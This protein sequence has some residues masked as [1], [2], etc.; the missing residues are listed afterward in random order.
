VLNILTGRAKT[1]KSQLILD[2]IAAAD[3]GRG[4]ILLVPEHAS[5]QA[6]VDLCRACGDSASRRAEV[7][8][9][10]RLCDRVLSITG[11]AAQVTLDAGGKLLTLEKALLEVAPELTVY[12]RPSRKSAFLRQLLDLFDELRCYDVS[13]ET[14]YDQ[15]QSITGATRDKLRDLSLLYGAYESRLRRPGLDARDRMTKLCDHLESSGYAL[16]KDIYIDGFTYFTAQERRALSILLRQSRSLTVTLLGEPDSREEIFEASLRTLERLRRLAAQEGVPVNIEVLKRADVSPLGHLERCFFGGGAPY[17]GDAPQIR[18]LQADNPFSEVEQTA[19]AIRRLLAEGKC[20]CRDVTVAARNMETYES[21]IE[22]VFERYDLPAYLSRRS[23]ILEKPVLSLLTGVLAAIGGGYEYDDMFRWLKTGLSGL[24]P[25]ECD[26]LENYVLKWEVH[27]GMWLRDVDWAENPDGYGAPWTAAR[28]ARLR[29]VNALRRRVRAPLF[30]LA[31]GLK[32][33]ETAAAKVDALYGFMEELSLQDALERQLRSQAE[34]GRLQEAEETAQL[35]EILCG[36]LDQFVEILGEEPMELEEFTRLFRQVLTQYSVG[37]I[38]VALDQVQ[39]S[40]VARNDRHTAQ[41]LFLL[42]ANDHVLPTPGEGGGI[43][44]ADDRDELA[45]RGIELAPTGMDQLAIELQN[46]YA[47]L[48][49]PTE[50]LTVS[51]PM[52]DVSGAELRPAFVVDRL[53]ALF[54]TLRVL[55][56]PASRPY[57]LAAP[58]PALE[59]AVPG[60][61]LW[62][63]FSREPKFHARLSAQAAAAAMTRGSLSPK[64]VRALYGDRVS[65]TASRLERIRSCH[66]AYFMEYGL[67]AQPRTPAA[68]DAPQIGTFLHYLLERVTRDVLS[69]GGFAQVGEETLHALVRTYIDEYVQRELRNFQNRNARF[70]Y[71]F[72][73]LRNLAYAVVDQAA[74][75]LRH[76]DFVPL[77]F[78]LSF[79]DGPGKDLPSVVISEPDGE[80]RVGGKVDRVDGWLKD[81]KL[82]LRV[83]DYKSGKKSFD[84]S[85]VRMGLDIQM[86]LY[87]FTLQKT[88]AAHFGEAIEPAGVL[89]LPARDDILSV[90]RNIPPEKL[91]SERE[92][93]LRRSGLLLA[94]PQVLQAMEHEA[95]TEPRYLP[96]RVNKSGNLSG[97]LASAVQLGKLAQYVERLLH[98]I[99][100]EIRQGNIDADPCCHTEED[101]HCRY[102]DWASACHFQDGRDG[103]HL[104]YILPVKPE[105]FWQSLETE[106]EEPPC[107]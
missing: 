55:R 46:L 59:S 83:V 67:K 5:H 102:C 23:D 31:E 86:L 6:E 51:W 33:G 61:A 42:G 2:R 29:Q 53:L 100:R 43:L 72:A 11:G 64:A 13:P 9:F 82:F 34:A 88:G 22:T 85:A 71:L 47:A 44:N 92:K 41:Y 97:S 1:G 60:G 98:D 17:D 30:R 81:G 66:F 35:W 4:Q 8:S 18:L 93:Q 107:P 65:M 103:D 70:R 28:E 80:L 40:G 74:E 50:G 104:N 52:A 94:E 78:E 39:V 27:G 15:S 89:Y 37:T 38:P 49:Q 20:R 77:A 95:L 48:A 96:L 84:L 75:E 99:A 58:L 56:E 63:Y 105:E 68:F 26:L 87:L 10:R 32:T 45:R 69:L 16:G 19:A 54:P 73:R 21:I 76:S 14:L 3:G 57:R 25:E 79:G 62:A 106:G 24:T 36:V 7:L 12:R 101:R 90:E 91:Q